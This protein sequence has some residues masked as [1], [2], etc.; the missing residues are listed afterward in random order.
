MANLPEYMH[1]FEED[2]GKESTNPNEAPNCLSGSD[3]DKN[4]VAC[5]PIE[6]DGP[7]APY[8]VKADSDGWK[9]EPQ[10][11][12]DICENGVPRKLRIFGVKVGAA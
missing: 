2:A 10:L 5:L 12:V 7:N 4:F 9:L 1:S 3:L 11:V 8:K 6:D